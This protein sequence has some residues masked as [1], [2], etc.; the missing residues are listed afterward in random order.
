[1][2]GAFARAA[3]GLALAV[4]G[5]LA[6]RSWLSGKRTSR[7]TVIPNC[8]DGPCGGGSSLTLI[9]PDPMNSFNWAPSN[10]FALEFDLRVAGT[11]TVESAWMLINWAPPST[12]PSFWEVIDLVATGVIA[13]GS[14]SQHVGPVAYH[15]HLGFFCRPWWQGTGPRCGANEI[16]LHVTLSDGGT[17]LVGAVVYYVPPK[18]LVELLPFASRP[19]EPSAV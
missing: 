3:T 16:T 5:W 7:R 6:I 14:A 10:D 4:S 17:L 8:Q 11:R 1:M 15:D 2:F 12:Q 13:R 19:S 18:R 9:L